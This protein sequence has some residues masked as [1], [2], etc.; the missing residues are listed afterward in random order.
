MASSPR[1]WNLTGSTFAPLGPHARVRV[2]A[3]AIEIAVGLLVFALLIAVNALFAGG[4]FALVAVDRYR[5]EDMVKRGMRGGRPVLEAL[6]TLSFQLSGAQLGITISSLILGWVVGTALQPILR[7]MLEWVPHGSV[8]AVT[9]ATALTLATALQ[10]VFGELLPKNLAIARPIRTAVIFVPPVLVFN[11]VA[12]PLITLLNAVANWAMQLVG[13]QPR[14]ELPGVESIEELR[15]TLQW[16]AREGEITGVEHDLLDRSLALGDKVAHDV[17]VPRSAVVS[18]SAAAT[19]ADLVET[20]RTTGYSRFPLQNPD[21][22]GFMSV[23]HVKDALMVPAQTRATTRIQ[24]SKQTLITVPESS[25]LRSLLVTLQTSG[26]AMAVVV[27]EFGD[28]AGI[29]TIENIIEEV[30]GAI[31]DEYDQPRVRLATSTGIGIYATEGR[32]RRDDLFDA[33]GFHMPDGRYDTLAGLV[34]DRFQRVPQVGDRVEIDGWRC[35]VIEMN[36]PRIARILLTSP[37]R[38]RNPV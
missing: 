30:L 37:S 3:A 14:D 33:T 18:L 6:R 26:Q 31:E 20:S 28:I 32:I 29:V 27:D 17:L 4:Q 36:G 16:A 34:L 24:P 10:M 5:I 1:C 23:A 15:S 19:Y 11:T 8:G 22:T 12:R 2:G 25:D 13:I 21:G 7:P 35:Q 9:A 38:I